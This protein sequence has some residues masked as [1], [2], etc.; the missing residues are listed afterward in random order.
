[1]FDV[2]VHVIVTS[3][4]IDEHGRIKIVMLSTDKDY[5]KLPYAKLEQDNLSIEECAKRCFESYVGIKYDWIDGK[6]L[7]IT[8]SDS[9]INVYFV[10]SIPKETPTSAFFFSINQELL[11]PIIQKAI[12]YS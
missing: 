10:C 5:F 1:M 12:R 7:D 4:D 2:Y 8:K 6:L 9:N 3:L 11:D